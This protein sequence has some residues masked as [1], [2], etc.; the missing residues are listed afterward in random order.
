VEVVTSRLVLRDAEA[1]DA[2]AVAAYQSDP[3][4]LEHYTERPDAE[5]IIR[6]AREWAAESPRRNFQLVVT[7]LD[8]GR[9]IGCAG[10]RQAG[11]SS[12][13]AGLGI[14]LDPGHWG[15]GY[16]RE[17]LCALIEFARGELGVSRIIAETTATNVRA[18]RLVAGLGFAPLPAPAGVTRFVSDA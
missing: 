13:E 8:G 4:Y 10:V 7:L 2:V 6:T 14:E 12:G 1:G 5:L 15:F 3:R 18:H 9:V 11:H 16:A 17:A